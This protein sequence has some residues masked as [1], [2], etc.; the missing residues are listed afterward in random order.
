MKIVPSFKLQVFHS[1]ILLVFQ[2]V[3]KA[4][5]YIPEVDLCTCLFTCKM[6]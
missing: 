2:A 6:G 5:G 1:C 4:E 3:V